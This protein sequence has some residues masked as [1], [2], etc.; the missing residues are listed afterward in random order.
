MSLFAKIPKWSPKIGT[1]AIPKLWR[2]IF[3]SNQIYF[4]NA[5]KIS[6]IPQKDLFKDV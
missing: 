6:Y 1:L 3:F 2:L 5:M 4:E